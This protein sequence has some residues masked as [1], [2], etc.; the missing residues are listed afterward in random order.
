MTLAGMGLA[1]GSA[2]ALA[3]GSPQ[4]FFGQ[5]VQ[6]LMDFDGDGTI[7]GGETGDD[8]VILD[9]TRLL[10]TPNSDM[11][12]QQFIDKLISI[13]TLFGVEDFESVMP[14]SAVG[15]EFNLGKNIGSFTTNNGEIF[16]IEDPTATN[17]EG[18]YPRSG[19]Q[20]LLLEPQNPAE[21]Q[22]TL[23]FS[24]PQI[25]VGFDGVDIGDFGGELNAIIA[26]QMDGTVTEMILPNDMGGVVGSEGSTSGSVLFWGI[27]DRKN[28]FVSVTLVRGAGQSIDGFAFDDLILA[29]GII[30]TPMAAGLGIA[31]LLGVAAR[32]RRSSL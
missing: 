15:L 13:P 30:P 21:D 7:E 19:S 23:T 5:D 4:V 27:I 29:S 16:R 3:S 14:G 25:A 22:V 11:M 8:Q 9:N 10:N 17:G 6:M 32:R 20:Y 18:R 26:R 31:G 2:T 1:F 28:P 24:Q 12:R